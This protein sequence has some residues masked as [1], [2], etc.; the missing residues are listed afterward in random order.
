MPDSQPSMDRS[1]TNGPEMPARWPDRIPCPPD[2]HT[3]L[4][5]R[6]GVQPPSTDDPVF[7][8]LRQ[9]VV[10]DDQLAGDLTDWMKQGKEHRALF[11]QALENGLADVSDPPAPL[12]AFFERMEH[13]PAW[14]DTELMKHGGEVHFRLGNIGRLAVATLGLMAGY[15]NSAVAKTLVST[16]SLTDATARRMEETAKFVFDVCDSR[17]MQRFSDGF[18]SA[19]RVRR[20]HAFV[21][22]GLA[23]SPKWRAELWGPPISVMDSLGTSMAFWVPVVLAEQDLGYQLSDHDKRA[24]MTLWNYVGYLQG[25]PEEL[26]P[27]SL[28]QSYRIYCALRMV[29]PPADQDSRDLAASLL[30][31]VRQRRGKRPW[32]RSRMFHGGVVHMLPDDYRRELA[33]DNTAFRIWPRLTRRKVARREATCRQDPAFLKQ[34]IARHRAAMMGEFT[35]DQ[36]HFDPNRVIHNQNALVK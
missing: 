33:I 30:A 1:P 20:V 15:R 13:R 14:A 22:R 6:L 2:I 7:D 17:G 23:R 5:K 21:R 36:G 3:F 4:A 11:D 12:R 26:L 10:D 18:K 19:I 16:G 8:M 24:M 34:T 25:V 9:A 29:S 35:E 27:T 28:E 32:L 31:S